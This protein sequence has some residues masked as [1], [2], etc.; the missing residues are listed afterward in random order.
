MRSWIPI[1]KEADWLEQPETYRG[2]AFFGSLAAV[3]RAWILTQVG[4]VEPALVEI[5]RLLTSPSFF[6]SAHTLRLDPRWDPIRDDPR[7]REL[8][9]RY[10][11][12]QPVPLNQGSEENEDGA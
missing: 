5:E 2:D 4:A 7:F 12:P 1:L 3:N 10:A 11:E 6:V 9:V 8:L